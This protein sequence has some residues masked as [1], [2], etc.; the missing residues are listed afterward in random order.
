MTT[1]APNSRCLSAP[2]GT[3][4]APE[5]SL[6]PGRTP[7][8]GLARSLGPASA[9]RPG[10]ARWQPGCLPRLE[11]AV[12]VGGLAQADSPQGGCGEGGGVALGAHDDDLR[13]GPR[14]RGNASLAAR[15]QPPLQHVAPDDDGP[16]NLPLG[17]PLLQG[18]DIDQRGAVGEDCERRLRTEPGQAAAG[19]S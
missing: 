17:D 14:E 1:S 16:R 6:N 7:G 8:L 13:I 4:W 18:P 12:E 3:S 15:V 5:P 11:A 19:L 2:P 9:G 10:R